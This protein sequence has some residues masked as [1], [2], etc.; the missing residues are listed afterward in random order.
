MLF[1]LL[2][3]KI[4]SNKKKAKF[5]ACVQTLKIVFP[6]AYSNWV[7]LTTQNREIAKNGKF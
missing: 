2:D 3:Q 4:A 1:E 7:Y 6:K 5:E